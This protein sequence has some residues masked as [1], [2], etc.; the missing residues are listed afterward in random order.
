M[1]E[2]VKRSILR[3]FGLLERMGG[4]E[5]TKRIYKIEVDAVDVRGKPPIKWEDIV[6]EYLRE[7][8]ERRLRG[9][10]NA[11]VECMDRSKWTLF[12]HGHPLEGVPRSRHQSRLDWMKLDHFINN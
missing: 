11:R 5:L 3:W 6:L 9:M 10:V 8:E 7:R 1:V 4:N 12:C 2:V